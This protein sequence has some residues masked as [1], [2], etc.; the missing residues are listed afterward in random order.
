MIKMSKD[1]D[2]CAVTLAR[3]EEAIKDEADGVS[4]YM[5]LAD[6]FKTKG[7]MK[8]AELVNGIEG[9]ERRHKEMLKILREETQK[10]CQ[11][12]PTGQ[13]FDPKLKRCVPR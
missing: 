8:S 13:I 1:S 5:I 11:R 6:I 12:C 7:A 4:S 2:W 3:L 9:D 10:A